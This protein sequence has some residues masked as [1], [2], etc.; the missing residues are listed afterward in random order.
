MRAGLAIQLMAQEPPQLII[1]DEPTNHL[2]LQ[3][4]EAIETILRAYQGGILAVS[5]DASFL[6]HIGIEK[7]ISLSKKL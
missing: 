7:T 2:D 4:I 6:E 3:A 5:H 1:L